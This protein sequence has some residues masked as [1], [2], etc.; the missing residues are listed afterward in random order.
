[1]PRYIMVIDTRS[2]IGCHSCTVCC[3]THNELEPYMIFNPVTTVGPIGT[4][5]DLNMSHI[6]LLCMHC[7]NPSCVSGC[8]TGAS[9]QRDDGIVFV[10]EN[11]C[12]SCKVCV[13]AC[14][15][16]ARVCNHE[17]GIVQKCDFCSD[18]VEDG[19][20]PRCVQS[21]HQKA[22]FFGDMND[23]KSEVSKL[24]GVEHTV[25]LQ[26]ELGNDP[27]VYYIF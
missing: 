23:P 6:A 16:G 15:Y 8:P 1:M 2:C 11:K 5:P 4:Y 7:E 9:Q 13:M 3:R 18:R 24:I 20:V 26:S 25:Q 27:R 10:D 22:R 14:P 19:K 12:V 17:R 21:C